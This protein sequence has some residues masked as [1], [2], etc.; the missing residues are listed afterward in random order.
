MMN[1]F[2]N[3]RNRTAPDPAEHVTA[4]LCVPPDV[5]ASP[6]PDGIILIHRERGIVYSANRVG[7]MIWRAVAEGRSLESVVDSI[8]GEF[9]IP[10][11][12]AHEDAAEFLAQLEAEGL[13]LHLGK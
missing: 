6:H 1:L 4:R 5:K 11:Q 2:W 3:K 7:A 10:R 13:L 9:R 12:T 8:G